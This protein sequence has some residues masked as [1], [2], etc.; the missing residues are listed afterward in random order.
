VIRVET[1]TYTSRGRT[2]TAYYP[3]I[4]F[5]TKQ[6]AAVTFRSAQNDWRRVNERIEVAYDPRQPKNAR[7]NS[8][9]TT[10]MTPLLVLLA[11]TFGLFTGGFWLFRQL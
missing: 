6:G 1:G 3:V 8:F 11:G 9:S 7:I 2:R 10:W 4:T 5:R